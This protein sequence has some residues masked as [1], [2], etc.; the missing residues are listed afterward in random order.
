M[1]RPHPWRI[2]LHFGRSWSQLDGPTGPSENISDFGKNWE[3]HLLLGQTTMYL[4]SLESSN[5]EIYIYARA[6][7]LDWKMGP[8]FP[9]VDGPAG[10]SSSLTIWSSVIYIKCSLY[11][12]CLNSVNSG[13]NMRNSDLYFMVVDKPSMIVWIF[14]VPNFPRYSGID[15]PKRRLMSCR[16]NKIWLNFAA[17]MVVQVASIPSYLTNIVWTRLDEM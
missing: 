2:K 4:V 3:N 11:R 7:P 6:W 15:N 1:V 8:S 10:R 16:R 17:K 14:Y 12:L 5:M 13:M 9:P